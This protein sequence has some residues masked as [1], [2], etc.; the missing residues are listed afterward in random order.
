MKST[1]RIT[2]LVLMLI[3]LSCRSD[4]NSL[5]SDIPKDITEVPRVTVGDLKARLDGGEAIVIV[6]VRSKQAYEQGHIPGA[7]HIPYSETI[8]RLDDF[9]KDRDIIF[10]CT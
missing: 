8:S 9:P 5:S 4:N 1:F 7:L 6:D 10:Y 3:G 2:V